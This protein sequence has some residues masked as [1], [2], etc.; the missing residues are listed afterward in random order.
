MKTICTVD[1]Y[2]LWII[3]LTS[4][5]V[6]VHMFFVHYMFLYKFAT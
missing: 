3:H 1:E 4:T 2:E 5:I 6:H